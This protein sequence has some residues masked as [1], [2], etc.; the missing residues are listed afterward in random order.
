[1]EVEY[2]QV[3]PIGMSRVQSGQ[4]SRYEMGIPTR[5]VLEG[6]V[7]LGGTAEIDELKMYGFDS[8]NVLRVALRELVD[9][10]YVTPVQLQ[11][12]PIR[13]IK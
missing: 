12:Q 8:P 11:P 3:T 2:Y 13:K 10:G 5:Q 7:E 6:I 1:M 9:L 4:F